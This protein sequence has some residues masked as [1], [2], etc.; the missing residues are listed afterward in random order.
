DFIGANS[1]NFFNHRERKSKAGTTTTDKK[2]GRNDKRERNFE[3]ELRAL[4][5]RALNVDFAVERIEVRANNVQ[6]DATAG[7]L[8]LHRS[9]REAWMEQ[10]LAK[11]AF[12]EAVR[13]FRRDQSALDG[14]LLHTLVIDAAAVVF[15][16]D[17]DVI[18]AMVSTQRDL[19]RFG[20]ATRDAI[21]G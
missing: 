14:A 19:T 15:D 13:G 20:F 16:F 11:V 8:G 2:R 21:D 17:V 1:A 4:T 12:R 3:R 5:R 7:E 6:T 10:H 9:G 18:A